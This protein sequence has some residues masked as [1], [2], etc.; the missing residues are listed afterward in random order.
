MDDDGMSYGFPS[1]SSCTD[2]RRAV[3]LLPMKLRGAPTFDA[4]LEVAKTVV[5][6]R[7]M[8]CGVGSTAGSEPMEPWDAAV[9][10]DLWLTGT[11]TRSGPALSSPSL[12]PLL[13]LTSGTTRPPAC[14]R[15]A[16]SV[17][18]PL[19]S[20]PSPSRTTG[21]VRALLVVGAPRVKYCFAA[22][23][24]LPLPWPPP[25]PLALV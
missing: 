2:A 9:E 13:L 8:W 15:P 6:W 11:S 25:A 12:P 3:R 21:D 4:R 17:P 18:P 7:C 24:T 14:R 5:G 19:P 1:S 16:A 20:S 10:R 23:L 22:P